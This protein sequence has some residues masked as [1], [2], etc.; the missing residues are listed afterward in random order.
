MAFHYS[1]KHKGI[2]CPDVFSL[3]KEEKAANLKSIILNIFEIFDLI[4]SDQF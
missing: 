1:D 4:F 3:S 2:I